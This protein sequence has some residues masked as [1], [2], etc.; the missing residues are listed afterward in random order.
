MIST[1]WYKALLPTAALGARPKKSEVFHEKCSSRKSD[2]SRGKMHVFRIF[3]IKMKAGSLS[4]SMD[5]AFTLWSARC[6]V[7][8]H[9]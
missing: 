2:V 4:A 1:P 8:P 7:K 6:G 9:H 5:V 3:S